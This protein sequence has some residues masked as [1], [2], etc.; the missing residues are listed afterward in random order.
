M[1]KDVLIEFCHRLRGATHIGPLLKHE[2][3]PITFCT[4]TENITLV[5]TNEEILIEHGYNN[6]ALII[7]GDDSTLIELIEGKSRLQ[8]LYK[9]GDIQIN[10]RYKYILRFESILYCCSK[11]A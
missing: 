9:R 3:F 11:V 6:S 7:K 1:I 5:I 8:Q 2:I 10:G 4:N